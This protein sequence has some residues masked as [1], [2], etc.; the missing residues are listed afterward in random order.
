MARQ[1]TTS[2]DT[3]ETMS[4]AHP[5]LQDFYKKGLGAF[6]SID[7][8]HIDVPDTRLIIGSIALDKAALN[9][10]PAD[11]RWDYAFDYEG[12]VFFIEV[13]PARASEIDTV[14]NKVTGLRQ[15]LTNI[16]ANLLLLPPTNRVFYWVSSGNTKMTLTGNQAR[17]LAL[18]KI[19]LTGNIW[20]YTKIANSYK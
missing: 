9:D 10:M 3:L 11:N 12:K 1:E 2:V 20:R 14:I 18:K 16:G 13:H 6:E 4:L 17:K 7:K 8:S 15:W 19:E 5:K